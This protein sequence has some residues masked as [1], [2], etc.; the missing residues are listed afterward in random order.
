MPVP[1]PQPQPVSIRPAQKRDLPALLPIW[2]AMMEEHAA[3]DHAFVLAPD[4]AS[5]WLAWM[6]ELLARPEAFAVVAQ[7]PAVGA[8]LSSASAS[9]AGSVSGAG[10]NV[11]SAA[12]PARRADPLG[13]AVGWVADN[14][15]IYAATEVGFISELAVAAVARRRRVGAALLQACRQW[16]ARRGLME[17]QL[18]TAVWNAPAQA[19]WRAMGGA[20]VLVRYRF[21]PTTAD[22]HRR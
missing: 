4:A 19:F 10:G 12:G 13:F 1:R 6:G 8:C 22:L 11:G 3:C 18:A 14:L 15:P 21:C 20:P 5:C 7:G 17:F 2:L 9:R 16:F